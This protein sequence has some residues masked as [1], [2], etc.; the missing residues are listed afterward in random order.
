MTPWRIFEG[1]A[2]AVLETLPDASVQTCVTSPPYWGLRDYGTATWLGGESGCD[3]LAPMPGGFKSSGLANFDNHMSDD[4]I[5]GIVARRRQ[6]YREQCARCGAQR[7]D[8]QLGLEATP[9][10]YVEHLVDVFRE[11]RRVL[12]DD[13][14]VWL[15]LGDSYATSGGAGWQG[16]NG[17]RADRAFTQESLR[18]RDRARRQVADTKNPHRCIPEFGP[19]RAPIDGLKPKDLVGIPWRVAFALQADG[20]WLRSDIVWSKPNPMPESI[21]DRPT[22]SHEYVFLLSK[23]ERYFFDHVAVRE[24]ATYAGPNSPGSIASPYGQGF[25]RRAVDRRLGTERSRDYD[26]ASDQFGEGTSASRRVAGNAFGDGLLRNIRSVWTIAT[27]PF[28]GSHFA[29]F[30]T[31]LVEPCILAGSSEKACGACGAPYERV[32]RREGAKSKRVGKSVEKNAAGLVTA[33]SGYEDGST[34]PRFVTEGWQPSCSCEGAPTRPCV[35]LDIFSGAGTTGLVANRLG[36]EFVGI[37]LNPTYAAMARDRI[38]SDAPLL[39]GISSSP[40][41]TSQLSLLGDA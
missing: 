13:G 30:P 7:V 18:V 6:Q 5:E 20:W 16:K 11:V 35:V 14:T 32:V 29:T 40:V 8:A 12:R 22:K 24:P 38:G 4:S 21:T 28:P 33:F 17:Q 10:L 36:R 27:E 15:N 3:H 2:L 23:R 26:G 25:T 34:A 37:E 19:N 39:G 41:D 1:D 9:E 31:K